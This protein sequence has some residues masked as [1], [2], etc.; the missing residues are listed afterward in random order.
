MSNRY[1]Q[2]SDQSESGG[3]VQCGWALHMHTAL[4]QHSYGERSLQHA[5][6]VACSE[7]RASAPRVQEYLV[8]FFF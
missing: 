7:A 1:D 3:I 8:C 6:Y 4:M 2:L 5:M